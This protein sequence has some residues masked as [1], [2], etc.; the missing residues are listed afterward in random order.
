MTSQLM[1]LA[2]GKLM[3]WN[4]I[5]NVAQEMTRSEDGQ[6][7][8]Y[9][10]S[11]KGRK[12]AIVLAR[13]MA[14]NAVQL[15][16]IAVLDSVTLEKYPLL[17]SI[18]RPFGVSI[19]PNGEWVVFSNKKNG[20]GIEVIE[21]R[22]ASPAEPARQAQV[23]QVGECLRELEQTCDDIA[24]A[25]DS[26]SVAWSDQRGMWVA[27]MAARKARLV[28]QNQV[29]VVDPQGKVSS[30]AVRFYNNKWSPDGRFMLTEIVTTSAGTRWQVVLDLRSG[31]TADVPGSFENQGKPISITWS[32]Q[33]W[34]VV[35]HAEDLAAGF[36]PR[37][38]R[39][40]VTPTRGDMLILQE[41]VDFA[42]KDLP[43][44]PSETASGVPYTP[45]W[46]AQVAGNVFGL[47]VGLPDTHLSTSL[48]FFD[49]S[50]YH[51]KWLQSVPYDTVS[52]LWASDG[53]GVLVLGW[54]DEIL[55]MPLTGAPIRDLRP[56]VGVDASA[57]YWTAP[58]PS[59]P[60]F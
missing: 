52:V 60:G 44:R 25:R 29:E 22:S 38:E 2:D 16:D 51:L 54:H 8:S 17:Q 58:V 50:N 19:S 41:R 24:W 12:I 3:R 33:G 46:L 20:G 57:F 32:D 30:I 39:W 14:V 48:F 6:V 55:Y 1:Y 18:T 56:V 45:S 4:P 34:L 21:T 35:A 59:R 23:F 13:P 36:P 11:A 31:K 5:S 49:F 27:D 43:P 42:V 15:F 40:F 37:I 28:N 26:W 9:S 47:G 53:A 7:I 10:V